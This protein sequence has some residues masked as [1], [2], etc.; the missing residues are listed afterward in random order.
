MKQQIKKSILINVNQIKVW[1]Y[2]TNSDLMKQW[3]GDPEMNI[4]IIS[5]WKVGSE[6]TIKG[7]HHEHFENK[8]TIQQLEPEV[9]FQ[10]N[11]LSSLSD[12]AD[13]P[14][15]YTIITF[16]LTPKGEQTELT[17]EAT[18]FPTETI[19]KHLEFYWNGTIHLLKQVIQN[20][21]PIT[22]GRTMQN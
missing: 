18:N 17:V 21:I 3:M 2:L 19:Y 11:F 5:D 12:L 16:I 4:E 9:I 22:I 13:E 8:G 7:F 15:N 14:N 6:F 20:S 10:Y 1:E